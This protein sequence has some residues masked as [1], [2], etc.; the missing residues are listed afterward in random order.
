[1][2]RIISF[3]LTACTFMCLMSA[4]REK[5]A[6]GEEHFSMGFADKTLEYGSMDEYYIAGYKGGRNP[7]GVLDPQRVK[8]IWIDNGATS[9]LIISVDCIGLDSGTVKE[10]RGSLKE[11]VK[12]S[13]CDSVNV[14]STHTHAGVDTLGLWGPVG[15]NGKNV[16]FNRQ[17]VSAAKQAAE[18]A[19]GERTEGKL[20]Y[21]TVE[22]EDMQVDSREPQVYDTKLYQLRF[23]PLSAEK[24]GIRII[25]F[26]A[27][28][29]SLRGNNLMI[30]SDFPGEVARRIGEATGERVMFLP[31]AIGGLI[32]TPEF[33][34]NAV[35]NMNIT[36]ERLTK[37]LLEPFEERSLA[38][39][40]AVSTVKFKTELENTLFIYYKFL[41]ILG[42]EVTRDIFGGYKL[43]SELTL[44]SL[45]DMTLALF[46]GELFPELLFGAKGY[47]GLY[48]KAGRYGVYDLMSVG[49]ANDELGYIIPEEDFVLDSHAPY[50]KEAEDHY[51]ETN[52]VGP[53]CAEDISTAFEK[54]LKGIT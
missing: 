30:S 37:Y 47:E 23:V 49:L 25:S 38:P 24:N 17:I 1:M 15:I 5:Q 31:A 14:V 54:A 11:L 7:V 32:M 19:Y 12:K 51:E 46:P 52:S 45:G 22:T 40:I 9:L 4:C 28:A 50:V 6:S 53:H 39:N 48:E 33:S 3:I 41:G 2:R 10:I 34:E 20:F 27:H 13:G 36:A 43:S 29:E 44:I 35:E 26:A 21:G 42:N 8:A 18:T 16:K